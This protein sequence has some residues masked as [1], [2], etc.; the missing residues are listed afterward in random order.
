MKKAIS[1]N[2][3]KTSTGGEQIRFSPLKS[4]IVFAPPPVWSGYHGGPTG[5]S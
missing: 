2:T 4:L 3:V 1:R 5:P